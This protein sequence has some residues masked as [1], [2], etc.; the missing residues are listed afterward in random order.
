[1]V[2]S[3]EKELINLLFIQAKDNVSEVNLRVLK[4]FPTLFTKK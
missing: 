4:D 3:K 2:D 1:M